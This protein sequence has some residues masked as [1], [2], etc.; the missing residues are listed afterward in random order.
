MIPDVKLRSWLSRKDRKD[1]AEDSPRGSAREPSGKGREKQGGGTG[2]D[3]LGAVGADAARGK[4]GAAAGEQAVPSAESDVPRSASSDASYARNPRADI[5]R[6]MPP[7]GAMSPTDEELER[8]MAEMGCAGGGLG[9]GGGSSAQAGSPSGAVTPRSRREIWKWRRS[10][11]TALPV[12][13]TVG[14]GNAAALRGWLDRESSFASSTGGESASGASAVGSE[15]TAGGGGAGGGKREAEDG[16][17]EQN[18]GGEAGAGGGAAGSGWKRWRL[19]RQLGF[20]AEDV[21]LM[22]EFLAHRDAW[23]ALEASP[24]TRFYVFDYMQSVRSGAYPRVLAVRP[25][26]HRACMPCPSI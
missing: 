25:H 22:R 5:A 18:G 13:G 15:G 21:R 1:G 10:R 26:P 4:S 11:T 9:T 14:R 19:S 7:G 2:L 20:A 24:S 6:D 8:A 17:G 23:V 3:R 12:G 16:G